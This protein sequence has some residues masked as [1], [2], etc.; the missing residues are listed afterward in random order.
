MRVDS[1]LAVI[2]L[3]VALTGCQQDVQ[4]PT[5]TEPETSSPMP[6]QRHRSGI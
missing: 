4:S 1:R 3:L 2:A 6:R 5:Q